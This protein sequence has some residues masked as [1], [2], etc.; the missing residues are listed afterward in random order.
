MRADRRELMNGAFE[1][2][3]HVTLSTGDHF[4]RTMIV[5]AAHFAF[6]HGVLPLCRSGT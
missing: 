6:S 3:E 5:I 1:A 4:E 2:V